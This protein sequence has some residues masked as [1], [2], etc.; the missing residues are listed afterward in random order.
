MLDLK[1]DPRW[2]RLNDPAFT[3]GGVRGGVFDL[4]AD[5]PAAWTGGDPVGGDDEFDPNNFL[6]EEFCIMGN[7]RF[8]LRGVMEL[9]ILGGGGRS[10]NYAIWAEVSRA[11]FGAYFQSFDDADQSRLGLMTG[12]F[13][14]SLAGFVETLG[15]TCTVR[16]RNGGARPLVTLNAADHPLAQQQAKGIS[17]DRMLDLFAASGLDLRP[18][19]AVTH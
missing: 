15:Q 12:T 16:P 3:A 14:N 17:L 8:F 9:A 6:S 2:M 18:A 1:S 10:L 11:S 19:L 5:R 4:S 7:S 13:A